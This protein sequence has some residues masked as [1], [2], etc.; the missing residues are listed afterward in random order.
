[1]DERSSRRNFVKGVAIA[2]TA[3]GSV[4]ISATSGLA[5]SNNH[6]EKNKSEISELEFVE[7]ALQENYDKKTAKIGSKIIKNEWKKYSKGKYSEEEFKES[8]FSKL[9]RNK[10]TAVIVQD[11]SQVEQQSQEVRKKGIKLA[12]VKTR[13]RSLK[14]SE[15]STQS[16]HDV[17]WL[18]DWESSMN[19][20]GVATV[21]ID[22]DYSLLGDNSVNAEAQAF[23]AG[24]AWAEIRLSTEFTP[25]ESGTWELTYPH[26]SKG[27]VSGGGSTLVEM[28]VDND[29][30]EILR[31]LDFNPTQSSR[32]TNQFYLSGGNTY[33]I[34]VRYNV[35]ADGTASVAVA[36]FYDD[37]GYLASLPSLEPTS[38]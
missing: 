25:D 18:T 3:I 15:V 10:H 36:D 1:M 5:K 37:N 19:S 6:R 33:E 11:Y 4:S 12:D 13:S 32:E 31:D 26:S 20:A 28:F 23:T 24:S 21:D 38:P 2:S 14:Q 27:T 9:S 30:E 22:D 34:G 35:T 8:L 16:S 7:S 29:Y 17:E